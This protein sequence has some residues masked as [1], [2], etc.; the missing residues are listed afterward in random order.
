M[1]W[2]AL[3]HLVVGLFENWLLKSY[4]VMM[5]PGH[6]FPQESTHLH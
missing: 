4:L 6:D 3:K 5:A 2:I 1:L